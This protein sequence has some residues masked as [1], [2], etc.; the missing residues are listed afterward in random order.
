MQPTL[1]GGVT[2]V[3]IPAG[4]QEGTGTVVM[5]TGANV[6]VNGGTINVTIGT[7]PIRY[8]ISQSLG[9]IAVPVKDADTGK[10]T[11][12]VITLSGPD[13]VVEGDSA[14][15][16]ISA[17]HIPANPPLTV[18]VLLENETGDFLVTEDARTHPVDLRDTSAVPLEIRTKADD[19]EGPNGIIKAT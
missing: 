19:P 2:K 1:Q 6:P 5:A 9:T 14:T 12:P 16:M 4:K 15:Y 3:T 11:T 10:P 7:A 17:S 13:A 18:S 8:I